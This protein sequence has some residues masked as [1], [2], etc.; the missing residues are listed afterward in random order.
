[1][2]SDRYAQFIETYRNLNLF[3]LVEAADIEKFRVPYGQRTLARLRQA[4]LASEVNGKLIF[5]GHRGCSKST[6]LAQLAR[7]MRD[8]D[9]LSPSFPLPTW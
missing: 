6:L 2:V 8:G 9:Q 5:T 7:Q 3:P 1:M 4:I